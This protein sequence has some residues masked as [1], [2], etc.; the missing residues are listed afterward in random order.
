[1]WHVVVVLLIKSHLITYS[2]PHNYTRQE[3]CVAKIESLATNWAAKHGK[4]MFGC[5]RRIEA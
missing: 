1:M 5:V 4:V 3:N 2:L